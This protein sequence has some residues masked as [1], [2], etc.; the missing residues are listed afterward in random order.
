MGYENFEFGNI[1]CFEA[2]AGEA[3]SSAVE[4][5]VEL[6]QQTVDTWLEERAEVL[7]QMIA[8]RAVEEAGDGL[9]M[10]EREASI[11]QRRA[12]SSGSCAM[13]SG[14]STMGYSVCTPVRL[15]IHG[16][17]LVALAKI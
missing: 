13:R 17:N 15:Y 4:K 12:S 11:Q 2:T 1:A 9:A 3:Q 14:D 16:L 8:G 6:E 7:K 5:I 10:T